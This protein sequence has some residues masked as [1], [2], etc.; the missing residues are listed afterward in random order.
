MDRKLNPGASREQRGYTI[1]E[2]LVVISIFTFLFFTTSLG[3]F[4]WTH[5]AALDAEEA[6]SGSIRATFAIQRLSADMRR[7]TVAASPD[8]SSL[9]IRSPD[10]ATVRYFLRDGH[11]IC[12]RKSPQFRT[13]TSILEGVTSFV[14]RADPSNSALI[15]MSITTAQTPRIGRKR[16]RSYNFRVLSRVSPSP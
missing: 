9:S 12:E 7:S 4:L 2:V 13:S 10:G 11:L 15:S 3:A 8:A 14:A 6:A 16:S 1:V 5:R